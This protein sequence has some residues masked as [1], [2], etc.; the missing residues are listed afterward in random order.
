MRADSGQS[1]F[2]TVVADRR[3]ELAINGLKFFDAP[4]DFGGTSE[5]TLR[6]GAGRAGQTQLHVLDVPEHL[7]EVSEAISGWRA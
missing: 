2:G 6:E 7:G 1:R 3:H 5:A 4:A